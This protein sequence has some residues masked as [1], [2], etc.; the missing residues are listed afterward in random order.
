MVAA[1][2]SALA[3]AW[4]GARLLGKVT[5]DFVRK[6]VGVMLLLLAAGMAAGLI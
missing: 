2:V 3:G 6:L 1:T 5:L 4:V